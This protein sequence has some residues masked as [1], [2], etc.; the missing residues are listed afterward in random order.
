MKITL[1]LASISLTAGCMTGSGAEAP[2]SYDEF[3]ARYVGSSQ[4]AAGT[5]HLMYDW[6]QPFE[7]EAQVQ[8]LYE[9]YIAAKTGGETLSEATVNKNIFG[10]IDKWSAAQAQNLTYCVSDSFGGLKAGVV[11]AM[12]SATAA[13]SQ[14]SAGK[15]KWVYASQYD[16]NCN[17]ST[18]TTFDVNPGTSPYAVS[19][20]PSYARNKRSVLVHPD[21]FNGDFPPEGILRHELGH[22]LGL[23]HETTRIEGVVD[24]GMQCF[25]DIFNE[26]LTAYDAT[27]VMTTPACMGK[28][29]KNKTLSLSA[30]DAQAIQLLYR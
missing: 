29:I 8:K 17:S 13:W 27:S 5:Q 11:S 26:P 16:A 18:P 21:T 12:A 6:D 3:K 9:A 24:Y 23:R 28:N 19:F 10:D 14:A 1:L 2:L 30:L 15:V 22:T 7:S 25:E 20:F 4:D